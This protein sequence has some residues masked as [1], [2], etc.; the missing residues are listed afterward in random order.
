MTD[1]DLDE[2]RPSAFAVAYRMLG[3]VSEA[4]DVVQE[5]LLRL[6]RVREGGERL[7]SPRAHLSTVPSPAGDEF[8]PHVIETLAIHPGRWM[9]GRPDRTGPPTPARAPAH[10][11]R[12]KTG[13]VRPVEFVQPTQVQLFLDSGDEGRVHPRRVASPRGEGP[14]PP[15]A[16]T[17]V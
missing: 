7:E 12:R 9:T 16:A 13:S 10:R 11:G 5:G 1:E 14:G 4:E 2:L 15:S 17:R 8:L 6:H 3:S